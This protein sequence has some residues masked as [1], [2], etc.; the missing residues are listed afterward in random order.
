[1]QGKKT[2]EKN[3]MKHKEINISDTGYK[4]ISSPEI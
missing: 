4:S 1:M 3:C 2:N